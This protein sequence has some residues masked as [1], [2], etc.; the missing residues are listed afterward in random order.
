MKMIAGLSVVIAA[1]SLLAEPNKTVE[2]NSDV[3]N[4]NSYVSADEKIH[5]NLDLYTTSVN[6]STNNAENFTGLNNLNIFIARN[7]GTNAKVQFNTRYGQINVVNGVAEDAFKVAEAFVTYA[8]NNAQ[9][10]VGKFF[11]AFGSFNPYKADKTLIEERLSS[12]NNNAAEFAYAVKPNAYVKVWAVKPTTDAV[13]DYYGAKLGYSFPAQSAKVTTDI[14]LLNDA[15]EMFVAPQNITL[16]K[17]NAVQGQVAVNYGAFEVSGK[18]LRASKLVDN[19]NPVIKGL[20]VSYD[21]VFSG[22]K[23][24]LIAEYERAS[25]VQNLDIPSKRVA[26]FVK[27]PIDA[28]ID[29]VAGV[30][31]RTTDATK[32]RVSSIGL[33][34]T[35]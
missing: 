6:D 19:I 11:S 16:N 1:T 31:E 10:K 8:V 29:L 32:L 5:G 15:R 23:A 21:T 28:N 22:H 3:F 14:S 13:K 30:S 24:K 12:L 34:A 2:N 35:I 25:N 33:K 7:L 9:V 18:V 26:V 27:T 17:G 4:G 20:S